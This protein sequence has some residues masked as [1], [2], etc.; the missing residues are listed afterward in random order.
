FHPLIEAGSLSHI[1]L[2]ETR[3]HPSTIAKFVLKTFKET[4]NDQITFSPEFTVCLDCGKREDS[5]QA[6]HRG[7]LDRCPHCGSTNL[8]RITRVTGFFSKIE[9]W[10]RGKIAELRDRRARDEDFFSSS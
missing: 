5:L 8:E 2:G 9:G 4:T 10:N 1:W 7:L 6:V 3:P